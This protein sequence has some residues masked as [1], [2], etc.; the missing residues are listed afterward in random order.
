M[1]RFRLALILPRFTLRKHLREGLFITALLASSVLGTALLQA[2]PMPID[3]LW[4]SE[5]FRK[6]ITASY[7]IDSRIEPVITTN[8]ADIIRDSAAA[9]AAGNREAAI[10]V[11]RDSSLLPQS[12]AMLFNLAGLEFENESLET[13][14]ELLN[15]ALEL[16]PNFRDAHRNLAVAMVRG[17][18]IETA[19]VHLYRAVELGARDALTLGLLGYCHAIDEKYQASLD[20]YRQALMTSP[21]EAQ[22]KLGEAQ[23]LLALN[24]PEGAA[25]IYGDLLKDTPNDSTLWLA[26]ADAWVQL[27]DNLKAIAGLEVARRLGDVPAASNLGLG[28]LYVTEGLYQ[29]ASDRYVDAIVTRELSPSRALDALENLV[30]LEQWPQAREVLTVTEA[31]LRVPTDSE[32]GEEAEATAEPEEPAQTELSEK[33]TSRLARAEAM[34]NMRDGD[35]SEAVQLLEVHLDKFP[36]DGQALLLLARFRDQQGEREIAEMLLERA[37]RDPEVEADALREHGQLLV[38]ALEYEKG[39]EKLES[40]LALDPSEALSEYV[41]AVREM[42]E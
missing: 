12:P 8:E 5:Q 36:L 40:S 11:Y 14:T 1:N 23:A 42:V 17:D 35:P 24:D 15:D 2:Q 26:Q 38:T 32:A 41:V 39:L 10:K 9:M 28:H 13:A 3:P 4:K 21:N 29:L 22:W 30:N 18:D 20:A 6:A 27:D 16:F 33:D 31:L 19:K 25:S 34:I 37:S 7:G